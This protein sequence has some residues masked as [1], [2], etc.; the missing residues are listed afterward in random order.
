MK[1]IFG[2][3]NLKKKFKDAVVVIGVFDGLHRGHRFLIKNAVSYARDLNKKSLCITFHPH[4]NTQPYL[5]SLKHRLKL[6]ALLGL[7]YCLVVSF[8]RQFSEMSAKNFVRDILVKLFHPAFIFIGENFRFGSGAVGDVGLLKNMGEVFGFKVKPIKELKAGAKIISS[9]RIRRLIR[10]GELKEAEKFLGRRVSVLGTVIKGLKRGRMLGYPTANINPHHE[11][12][13]KEGVY[14]VRVLYGES[15]Y[16]GLC[17]IGG[18]P[19]FNP[20]EDTHPVRNYR[21]RGKKKDV[22]SGAQTIEVHLFNFKKNI[23]GK[24]V[25]IQFISKLRDEKKFPSA[26]SLSGQIKEDSQ[27]AMCILRKS[28]PAAG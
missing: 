21:A 25:E 1:T 11:V 17:N 15:T 9:M 26:L 10:R 7:D 12:L 14:A 28:N 18:R 8:N 6:I 2:L 20:P 27:R 16:K 13:P 24:D 5:I 22:S 23:Y 3:S 19:T 4:P